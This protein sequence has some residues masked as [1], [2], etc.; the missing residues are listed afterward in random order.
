MVESD[1][2]LMDWG[3]GGGGASKD[4]RWKTEVFGD[5]IFPNKGVTIN[6]HTVAYTCFSYPSKNGFPV[7]PP[8][9]LPPFCLLVHR[10]PIMCFSISLVIFLKQ[11]TDRWMDG[12]M[13][14]WT[15]RISLQ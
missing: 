2:L 12:R 14:G 8:S 10:M 1:S 7:I 6:R 9:S 5:G 11:F 3:E 15:N 4:P 13:D